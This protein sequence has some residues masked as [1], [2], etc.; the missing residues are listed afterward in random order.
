MTIFAGIK[1]LNDAEVNPNFRDEINTLMNEYCNNENIQ[2]FGYTMCHLWS[3]DIG[4]FSAQVSEKSDSKLTIVAG[5]P[6]LKARDNNAGVVSDIALINKTNDDDNLS[7]LLQSARGTFSGVIYKSESNKLSVFTD[8]SG[9]RPV[10]YFSIGSM[11]V[12]CSSLQLINKLSFS[13][14]E[15]NKEALNEHMAMGYCF[16]NKTPHKSIFRLDAAEILT[17]YNGVVR[18][19]FYWNW[20]AIGETSESEVDKVAALYDVFNESI[21][22]R[23]NTSNEQFA[24]LSGGL[25]SRVITA[26]VNEKS[27]MIHTFN[28]ATEGSQDSVFANL[29]AENAKYQH[30]PQILPTLKYQRWN[31]LIAKVISKKF[32]MNEH[33]FVWSGDGGS[34]G[35]GGVY[36]DESI[37]SYI[38]R[39]DMDNAA[40]LFLNNQKASLL[41]SYLN[42]D[43]QFLSDQVLQKSITKELIDNK[44]S[45]ARQL[46]SF[47]MKNDQ[48]RHLDQH[49]ETINEHK[50]ELL[51]PFFD[52][53][54][55]E[56]ILNCNIE[57]LM[58]H[59]LYM[60]WFEQ[61]PIKYRE[62]PWQTYPDHIPCPIPYKKVISQWQNRDGFSNRW[63]DFKRFLE[64]Y[65]SGFSFEVY[66]RKK[67][68][69]AM[70]LHLLGVKKAGYVIDS[71]SRVNNID[72][73]K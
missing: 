52:S 57:R 11:F 61:F 26:S 51:L 70:F 17:S 21:D 1:S 59:S 7:L 9:I 27:P 15:I 56:K 54:F 23:L 62:T 49:F 64:L 65:K 34:V 72:V 60:E 16:S 36:M 13:P 20:D 55:L 53:L 71:V 10:Y 14:K 6:I 63:R 24:F 69:I 33:C 5:E 3:Y 31:N 48:K 41:T 47:L 12:F 66:N 38:E 43:F 39:G 58:K 19:C 67:V 22:C 44:G 2:Q 29:L 18:N 8:K 28:F 73:N 68:T 32:D 40:L 37:I 30:E 42:K 35:L 25:D 50:V 4:A 45:G 46:Y